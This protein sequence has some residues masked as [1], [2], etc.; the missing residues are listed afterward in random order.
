MIPHLQIRTIREIRGSEVVSEIIYKE[1]SYAIVGACMEVHRELGRGFLEPVY[2]ESL[3]REFVFQGIPHER[4]APL[5]IIF[6]GEPLE[7]RYFADFFC[8]G[9]VIVETKA[10]KKLLPEHEAQL[11]NYLRASGFKL[12]LLANFGPSSLET[13]RVVLTD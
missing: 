6:K 7:K 12:G 10:V 13:K 8:Y 5:R 2:Q 4:E 1:E 11:F 9:K 3:E